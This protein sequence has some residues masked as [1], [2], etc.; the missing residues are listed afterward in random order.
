MSKTI[1]IYNASRSIKSF[2]GA[3]I[4]LVSSSSASCQDQ[5]YSIEKYADNV[6][7]S[8]FDIRFKNVEDKNSFKRL[9]E[10]LKE[11][12]SLLSALK[13]KTQDH[14]KDTIAIVKLSSDMK[15]LDQLIKG[16]K[17]NDLIE[18]EFGLLYSGV[19]FK[20]KST[21]RATDSI[22][23]S[24]VTEVNEHIESKQNEINNVRKSFQSY[25]NLQKNIDNIKDDIF[26]C[27][28]Q[29]DSA[30]A[31][32]YQQQSFRKNIS[33][34]FAILIGLLLCIFF[35][36]VY[37]RSDHNLSKELLSG[38]GLQ[39]VTLFVL[40][41]AVILFGI[42]SILGSSELAAIL[43]GISGYILGKGTQKDLSSAIIERD[44]GKNEN[45]IK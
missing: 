22:I 27:S 3:F 4:F 42:L 7:Q 10:F 38:N 21:G 2:L 35:L 34:S 14:E 11:K 24:S 33:I 43:S 45:P 36:I 19:S 8:E 6:F 15:K 41:I 25:L 39:F 37:L 26:K 17:E 31:P 44:K 23:K 12:E 1:I 16:K 20:N 5:D 29:I 32:E 40:I 30:L 13:A 9:R 28:T 18:V